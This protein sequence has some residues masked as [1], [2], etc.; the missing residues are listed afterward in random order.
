VSRYDW[1]DDD[2]P[3]PDTEALADLAET[4]AE[5]RSDAARDDAVVAGHPLTGHHRETPTRPL[6][7]HAPRRPAVILTDHVVRRLYAAITRPD[8]PPD[9]EGDV[10]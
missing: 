8:T 1:P 6:D 9:P 2:T 10:P 4:I 7:A 5:A 3:R